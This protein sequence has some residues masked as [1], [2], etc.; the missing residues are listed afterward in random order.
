[1]R[2]ETRDLGPDPAREI[3]G[4]YQVG[5]AQQPS[6]RLRP[7][8]VR[9]ALDASAP[10]HVRLSADPGRELGTCQL[11]SQLSDLL[12]SQ[13]IHRYSQLYQLTIPIAG[14]KFVTS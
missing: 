9:N 13:V 5:A 2:E 14:I 4:H 7:G 10:D 8:R 3:V 12:R 11:S 1:M 6:Q